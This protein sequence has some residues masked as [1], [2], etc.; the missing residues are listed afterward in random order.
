MK[1]LTIKYGDV[2]VGAREDFSLSSL[3]SAPFTNFDNL[4]QN[5]D[6]PNY[7]N[8]CELY[9]TALD[10]S[11]LL[12]PENSANVGWWSDQIS[13]ED[14]TFETPIEMVAVANGLYSSEGL[15]FIF[16]EVNGIY[17]NHINIRWYRGEEMLSEMD[18]SPDSAKYF[19]QNR[20][21]Y[22]NKLAV[23]FYSINV[24]KNRLKVHGIEYG[25]GVEFSGKE[26][27]GVSVIQEIS[28]LSDEISINTLD[29]EL[30]SE[31]DVEFSFKDRQTIETYFDGKLKAKTFIRDFKRKTK[32]NWTI[33]T[34][35]YIGLME[36]SPFFGG[37]YENVLAVD[38]LED[39]FGSAKVPYTIQDG[40]FDGIKLS[41]YIPFTNCREA[42]M[43][44]AFAMG[45]VVDT[46][47]REDV[48]VHS[49]SDE[50]SQTIPLSRI[51]QGQN[52]SNET[53]MTAF[54]LI[55]HQYRQIDESVVLYEA[56][57]SGFGDNIFVKFSQP[58][59]SL[60]IT[61]ESEILSS[62]A[63]Y[64][65]INARE[66]C[67][68]SGKKYEHNQ[69]IKKKIN[70]LVL[71]ADTENVISIRDATLVSASNVD[72]LLE[73]CYNY[74]INN[75]IVNLKIVESKH[76]SS[77][78]VKYGERKYGAFKYGQKKDEIVYDKPVNVG[79]LIE[80]ETEYLG[81]IQGRAVKQ[82]F[83]LNGGII[84]KNTVV[85]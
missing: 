4:K 28:P 73:K 63:N 7:T 80:I 55:A 27:M 25:Y 50:L 24:P 72:N 39:I 20:V 9:S 44:V 6:F 36:T 35:D 64:A 78:V 56:E 85:R 21:D 10:G 53:K 1:N 61:S 59:H 18:F 40:V 68:L 30:K 43:Q 84:I 52:F 33:S 77:G 38:L 13:G 32:T 71:A 60:S 11:C 12:L 70:P 51:M 5:I 65:V 37:V 42:L 8:L 26:L 79:D 74:Y 29:F 16:D 66:G 41:G 17:P 81:N 3:D 19:C 76:K 62:G 48:Y 67:V 57:K 82:T 14:G 22:Y 83:N 15:T 31:R 69:V 46:S 75:R 54:E 34:E 45:A 23:V 2:A 58:I 49:L 47:N